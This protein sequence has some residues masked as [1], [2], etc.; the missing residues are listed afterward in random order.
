M[1]RS[2]GY[3]GEDCHSTHGVHIRFGIMPRTLSDEDCDAIVQKLFERLSRCLDASLKKDGDADRNN[4][5]YADAR[6][7]AEESCP[8]GNPSNAK[9]VYSLK[10]LSALLGIST[11]TLRRLNT[12]GLIRSLPGIRHKIFSRREVDRFINASSTE[13]PLPTARRKRDHG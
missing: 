13:Q 4:S 7:R 9:L 5:A 1:E 6:L 12:R 2:V 10:E 8:A 11:L 3:L